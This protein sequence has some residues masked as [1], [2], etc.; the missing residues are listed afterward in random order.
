MSQA[1]IWSLLRSA[2]RRRQALPAVLPAARTEE[3]PHCRERDV[4]D[5]LP[6]SNAT[7]MAASAGVELTRCRACGWN[8]GIL[9][10]LPLM[11]DPLP[12]LNAGRAI[13]CGRSPC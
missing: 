11:A 10:E 13:F 5:P 12:R 1:G 6:V 2:T 8:V 4:L 3:C 7:T 9:R